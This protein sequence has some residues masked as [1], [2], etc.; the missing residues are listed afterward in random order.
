MNRKEYNTCVDLF[1]DSVYRFVLKACRNRQLAEDVVQDSFLVLWEHVR[2]LQYVKAKA[3]LF[4]TAYRKMI[5]AFRRE[6]KNVDIESTSYS[7]LMANN[8]NIDLE[9]ILEYALSRLP[10]IQ[11]TVILLRDYEDY[12]YHEIAEITGLNESQVKVYIF[13]GRSSM[14]QFI[15]KP[16]LVV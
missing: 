14:K 7:Q 5:D 2:E 11:Q 1:S 10:A 9:D 8:E 6:K 12:S 13:R 4:T 3:F 15:G 16:D